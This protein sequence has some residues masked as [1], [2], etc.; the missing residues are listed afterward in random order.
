M[1]ASADWEPRVLAVIATL[2]VPEALRCG[3]RGPD[4]MRREQQSH[5][6]KRIG[7]PSRIR[8]YDT[9]FRNAALGSLQDHR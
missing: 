2:L 9:R 4:L 6:A 5:E 3:G 1:R 8:T 7:A